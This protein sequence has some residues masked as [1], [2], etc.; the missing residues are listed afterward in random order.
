MRANLTPEEWA[1]Y[2]DAELA[3]FVPVFERLGLTLDP[4]QIHLGGERYLR[5]FQSADAVSTVFRVLPVSSSKSAATA[6]EERKFVTNM[7]RSRSCRMSRLLKTAS[8]LLKRFIL[9]TMGR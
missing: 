6:K 8:S 1:T 2:R 7:R 9:K 5:H 3:R 4:D